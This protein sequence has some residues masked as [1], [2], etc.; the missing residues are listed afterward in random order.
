MMYSSLPK[1]VGNAVRLAEVVQILVKH[2]FADLVRRIGLHES[3][4]ARALRRMH[5]IDETADMPETIGARL[6]AALTEL[7]PTF[8]KYGQILST[9]PDLIGNQLC[10]ELSQ[11]QDRVE[12]QPFDVMRPIIEEELGGPV[13]TRFSEFNETA[14]ASASL[15]QVYRARTHSGRE[16]AVKVQRPGVRAKI[17]SDVNLLFGIAEWIK[18][19]VKEFAWMD[20]VGMIDE[21]ERSILRELDF[22]IEARV[23]QRFRS[24]YTGDDRIFIPKVEMDLSGPR[25]LTMDWID[26]VRVDALNK[27]AERNCD[28]R[29]VAIIGCHASFSQVFEHH[30]FHADPH[31]GNFLVTRNN[32]IAF[33]DYGMVGHLERADVHAMADLLRAV[34]DEDA[35]RC[36][37]A[38]LAFT[39]GGDVEDPTAFVHEIA[40]YL[41]FEAQAIV[42]RADVGRALERV[43]QILRRHRLQLAPRFS[44][45]LK[46]MATIE[47]TARVLDPDIDVTPIMRP[48]VEKIIASRFSPQQLA[49]EGQETMSTLLRIGRQLPSDI[50]DL[51]RQA[52]KGKFKVQLDH[53]GLDHLAH[54]TDR[55]SNRIAFSVIAGSLIVGSS[56]LLATN[57]GARSLG[58][59]GFSIAG[60]L[61]VMLLIS[62]L[63]S[64]NY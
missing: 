27:Y 28:P 18:E 29:E 53:E 2:G 1:R 58:Y 54:V 15:S 41:A 42:G 46:A 5:L 62:I 14:V 56:L 7:G 52:R 40:A 12:A 34:F 20:P 36:A 8:V 39:K 63:R 30:I 10:A 51:I 48:Y 6:R 9:R 17:V 16:V 55:A 19:H 45:L 57:F 43:T 33:L 25:V 24:I 4:P 32:Q 13:A 59:T 61:G 23:I 64:K 60:V 3:I 35:V 37:T 11:L 49:H 38:L 31:P 44:M 26:G 21:F 50:H 47:S 22:T